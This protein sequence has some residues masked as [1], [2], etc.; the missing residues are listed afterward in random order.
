MDETTLRYRKP[1]SAAI[2]STQ[3]TEDDTVDDIVEKRHAQICR[4]QYSKTIGL[5]A[6]ILA[7]IMTTFCK[8]S[9]PDQV[10]FDEVHFGKFAGYYL[11]RTYYFDVHP[12]LGK[13]MNAA[14]GYILGFDGS[15]EFD[16]IGDKYADHN[17]PYIGMRAL[18]AGLN[19]MSTA[20]IFGIMNQSG[21]ATITCM[22]TASMYLLDN[23]MIAQQRLIMLDSA[24]IF[25]M[26]ATIYSYIRFYKLRDR[27]FSLPWF[28]WMTATAAAMGMT[29]SVK[30]VGLFLVGS[31]GTVVLVDIWD[32]LDARRG[33]SLKRLTF[34]MMAR[35]IV[36]TTV[37]I[38]VYLFWFYLHFAILNQS[39]P[40]DAYMSPRF[41]SSLANSP[42]SIQSLDI[43]FG[44]VINLQHDETEA[45]L[46]SNENRYPLRYEDGRISSQGYQV[47]GMNGEPDANCWWRVVRAE[48]VG[49][50]A[51]PNKPVQHGDVIQLQ[52]VASSRYLLTHDVASPT[53]PTNQEFTT[54]D[55]SEKNNTHTHF[56]VHLNDHANGQTWQ[57]YMKSAR[58]VHSATSVALWTHKKTLL[59]EWGRGHQ[60]VN[61]NKNPTDK[62]NF[63]TAREIRGKNATEI[64]MAK[65][66]DAQPL[67]F[68]DK[69][70][71]LQK[72]MLIH[73]SRLTKP[74]PYQSTPIV[75][76]LMTK[77][78]SYWS[79][80]ETRQ[81]IYL[82]GNVVGWWMMLLS[83][84]FAMGFFVADQLAQRR[85]VSLLDE[86]IRRRFIRSSGFFL[87][88]YGFHY[89]PFYAMGRSLF[90]HHYLP[91]ATCGYLL[92]GAV[93]QFLFIRGVDTGYTS[94]TSRAQTSFKTYAA[95]ATILALQLYVYLLLSPLT[96]GTP[97]LALE[98][99]EDRQLI[100][101]WRFQHMD[102]RNL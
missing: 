95:A 88:L 7:S 34:H 90:L 86:R 53:I 102:K 61:G 85:G 81:Q 97:G 101:G 65:K 19:V 37:P 91:A 45:Y 32:L 4:S 62:S 47:T 55:E 33:I 14:V 9:H 74:H 39:G 36:F 21:Y 22:L 41:Q 69:F 28:S 68:L 29:L 12:P 63:W 87:I 6:V 30:M 75:W 50:D 42:I 10:V 57:T 78:I 46:E 2:P 13:M 79:D 94:W 44:D 58:L 80:K 70:F 84:T 83:N 73:N 20:L 17:V 56:K 67:S 48:E 25:Y 96:Y 35:T 89:L 18:P 100:D 23:A 99:L 15:Y 52:H 43:H 49:G 59:P 5:A 76:P 1:P 3:T 51:K 31:I 16:A 11:K 66:R 8:L 93:F 40:G 77:G 24:L 26:L 72:K 82:L 92:F 27:P 38:A 98:Q 64:N 60:E 54:A 71:E